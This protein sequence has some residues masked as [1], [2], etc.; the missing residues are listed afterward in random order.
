MALLRLFWLSLLGL[1]VSQDQVCYSSGDGSDETCEGSSNS[2]GDEHGSID[3]LIK[4][5]EEKGG[6]FNPKLEVRAVLVNQTIEEGDETGGDEK[7]PFSFGLFVKDNESISKG[8]R[9]LFLPGETIIYLESKAM[10]DTDNACLLADELVTERGLHN[11]ETND[12][13]STYGPYIDFLEEYVIGRVSLPGSWSPD[14]KDLLNRIA[15]LD[16]FA[17]FVPYYRCFLF[18]VTG[19]VE[20]NFGMTEL[21]NSEHSRFWDQHVEVALSRRRL[22]NL[23]IPIYD[24]IQ[25]SNNPKKINIV[26]DVDG[27]DNNSVEVHASRDIQP[28]EE[29]MHSY[30][31]GKPEYNHW[32]GFMDYGMSTMEMLRDFGFVEPYP[33]RWFYS[34]HA[35][36]FSIREVEGQDATGAEESLELVWLS[37]S[38]PDDD[39]IYTMERQ[40]E[41]LE[42]IKAELEE[43]PTSLETKTL[44]DFLSAYIKAVKMAREASLSLRDSNESEYL[45]QEETVTIDNMDNHLFQIYQTNTLIQRVFD[46]D[47]EKIEELQSTYQT[48]EYYKDRGTKDR[49]LYLDNIYQ[50]CLV[51][52]NFCVLLVTLE[53]NTSYNSLLCTVSYSPTGRI[54]MSL[55]YT[56]QPSMSRKI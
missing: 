41:E 14:A 52:G 4:W 43:W 48:I 34:E 12:S 38:H 40:L 25:H 19:D 3:A 45:L 37:D 15:D 44:H 16:T 2:N 54:I 24:N 20:Y 35:L 27:D 8:E 7:Q 31:L 42:I 50:Q 56:S 32:F 28:N 46:D 1:A 5:V 33:Q 11:D 18:D 47:F 23:L 49:C 6:Y 30:G 39:A 13:E 10:L 9:I 17:S 26:S 36:D 53:S 55:W 51:S 29:I 21:E 22:D